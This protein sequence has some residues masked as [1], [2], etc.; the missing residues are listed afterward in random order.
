MPS[1]FRRW[2]PKES[3]QMAIDRWKSHPCSA[4]KVRTLNAEDVSGL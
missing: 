2:I 3:E 4:R 1:D